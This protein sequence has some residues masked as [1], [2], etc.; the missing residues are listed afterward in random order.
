MKKKKVIAP[1]YE[2]KI[3]QKKGSVPQDKDK[4]KKKKPI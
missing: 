4:A 3:N 2:N 1:S